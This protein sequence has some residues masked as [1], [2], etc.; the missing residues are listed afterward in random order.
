MMLYHTRGHTHRFIPLVS[1][2]PGKSHGGWMTSHLN[3]IF[4]L[5]ECSQQPDER[6]RMIEIKKFTP[7]ERT[8]PALLSTLSNTTG[9]SRMLLWVWCL[10][11]VTPAAAILGPLSS[12]SERRQ[13]KA[14]GM[15][16][17]FVK[18]GWRMWNTYSVYVC[19]C[20]CVSVWSVRVSMCTTVWWT[21][22]NRSTQCNQMSLLNR[23]FCRKDQTILECSR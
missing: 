19:L 2:L 4:I 21:P 8:G 18:L 7:N 13:R 23:F 1:L 10:K 5:N 11:T 9:S 6:K 12:S 15:L 22:G 14:R 20:D 3:P 16:R 17:C